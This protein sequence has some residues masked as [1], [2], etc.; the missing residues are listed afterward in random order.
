MEFNGDI[1]LFAQYFMDDKRNF[2]IIRIFIFLEEQ[3]SNKNNTLTLLSNIFALFP[4]RSGGLVA[5]QSTQRS[6]PVLRRP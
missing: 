2:I 3:R 5:A 6:F 4:S 1:E